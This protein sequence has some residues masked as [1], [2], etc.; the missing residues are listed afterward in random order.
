MT[1][2]NIKLVFMRE[3]RDQ[4]R[5]RRTLFMI[6]ILPL[7]L[8]PALGIGMLY[9]TMLFSEQPRT[10]VILGADSLPEPELVNGNQ[11]ADRWFSSPT[12][13]DKLIV[14]TDR[15]TEEN[16]RQGTVDAD[17][18]SNAPIT[19]Y[20][21]ESGKLLKEAKILQEKYLH[22]QQLEHTEFSELMKQHQDVPGRASDAT[23]KKAISQFTVSPKIFQARQEFSLLFAESQ[24]QVLILIPEGFKQQ[25][26][27]INQGLADGT[28]QI[29]DAPQPL[30]PIILQNSADE[31]SS[32]AF[33]R[34]Q[35]AILTWERELLAERLSQAGLPAT[36]HTPVNVQ[37]VDLA[38]EDQIAANLWSKLFP[39]L[40]IIMAVTGAFYPA[41]DLGAGEKER[42]T[43]ET[44]L[45][46]PAT[47]TEIVLGKFFTVFVF[48]VSTALLNLC[49]LGL[50]GKYMVSMTGGGAFSQ[51]GDVA[52]PSGS[53]VAWLLI[54]LIP[55]A[56]LFSALCLALATFARSSKEGQYYLTPL[57]MVSVGMTMF[58]LSPAVEIKPFFSIMPVMGVALLLKGLL[59][60]PTSTELTW[61]ALPVLLTSFAY[62]LLALWWAIEQF[63]SEEVL[64]REAER[65]ELRLWFK[66]LLRDKEATPSFSEAGVC[67]VLIMMLQFGAFKF[68][69]DAFQ[70]ATAETRDI[71]ML[72]MLIIQQLVIIGSPAA[73]MGLILTKSVRQTFLVRMPHPWMIGAAVVLPF[74]LN[75]LSVELSMRLS[76]FFPPLPEGAQEAL[77]AMSAESTP[78]WLA[79]LAFALAPALCEEIAFRGFI[80]SGFNRTGRIGLAIS[81]SSLTFGLMHMIPQQVFNAMLLGLVLGLLAIRS[82]SILPS[83]IF[84]FLFN[85]L[86]V[87]K[88][89][90][91]EAIANSSSATLFITSTEDGMH[92]TGLTLFL[93]GLIA[94]LIL[95]RLIFTDSAT[96][97]EHDVAADD[98]AGKSTDVMSPSVTQ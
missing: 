21:V 59:L 87:V 68:L 39:A 79:L 25:I 91:G 93:S 13:A 5:D 92:Y 48:S 36:L 7:L 28:L 26:H 97:V 40:M 1:W 89:R 16:A 45:I 41:I 15:G 42:G 50:T 61:Y 70:H 77:S 2:K 37:T 43:M 52:L 11:F 9:M 8:Y 49:C 66:H 18:T 84:H 53:S 95:K 81:L 85:G 14:Y 35:D 31:K 6:A 64:F 44:L 4:L 47:R 67:F 19:E 88:A 69:G 34:V 72:R 20:T 75:P 78:I 30:R 60:D 32:I 55:L 29:E 54:L 62:G 94:T 38:L 22:L 83:I 71:L 33:H 46:S 65:F 56:T 51:I 27:M 80:L 3:V 24:I 76:W 98:V 10:V 58:C 73:F 82:G 74:V 12:V 63:N 57:L 17:S 90:Y 86:E 23:I 96:F